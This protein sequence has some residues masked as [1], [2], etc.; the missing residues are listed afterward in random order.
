MRQR[1][2]VVGIRINPGFGR[3]GAHAAEKDIFHPIVIPDLRP[4]AEGLLVSLASAPAG[5]PVLK[6]MLRSSELNIK[7][8]R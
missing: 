3:H 8:P 1:T 6:M 7:G 2:R 4:I 5:S